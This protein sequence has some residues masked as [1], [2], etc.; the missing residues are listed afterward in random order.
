MDHPAPL[1]VQLYTG[2]GVSIGT[3][4]GLAVADA[5]VSVAVEGAA[6]RGNA[7]TNVSAR[8]VLT[9]EWE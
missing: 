3:R 5:G 9:T 1:G 4:R 8:L 7:E 6:L 2:R